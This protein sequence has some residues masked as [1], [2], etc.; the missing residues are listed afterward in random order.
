MAAESATASTGP[1]PGPGPVIGTTPVI[2][3]RRER[4]VLTVALQAARHVVLE[5]P[6]GTGKSTLLRS[7]ARDLDQAVVFVEGNAELTPA[8]LVG[9]YDPAQ[10][11]AEGYLPS[12]FA[13]GPL[14]QAMRSGALLYLEEFNRVP[15]ETL[16]VLITV[17]AEGEIAVPRLGPVRADEG[18]RLIAAMNPFDAIGTA[19]VSQ[20]IAD[21][22]CRV[23]LDYQD[24]AAERS[25]VRAVTG[26]PDGDA[27]PFAVAFA[28][29]TR[30][31]RDV[32]MGASVRG[33][34]DLVLLIDGL[35]RLR[36]EAAMT[37]LT[38]KDAAYAALSGRI[39]MADGCDRSPESV[40]DEILGDLWPADAARPAPADDDTP[41]TSGD[42]QGKADGPPS[43]AGQGR[44]PGSR[45]SLRRERT[46][47]AARRSVSRAEL[48]SRHAG[49]TD[50]SP[51]SGSLD[52]DALAALLAADP[53]AAAALLA[54]LSQATDP[55]LRAAA[56]Q[57]A[58]RI[59]IQ[60]GVAGRRSARGPRRIRSVLRGEGDVDLDRTLDRLGGT[61]PPPAED[62][63]TR[64]WQAHR[65]SVCLLVDS[66]G[67][68][69]GL[70]VAMA[71]VA[72][73]SVLLAAHGRLDTGALAFSG[74][75]TVLQPP[76]TR[77]PPE[78]IVSR[79]LGLRGHGMTDIAAALRSAA[80]LLSAGTSA[81]AERRVILMS[82][83]LSTT[84]G[85]PAAAL[86]G[87]ERLDVLCPAPA[88]TEPDPASIAAAER[89]ARLG[90]GISQPVRTLAE[91]PAALTRLLSD[92]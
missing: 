34:I 32:R 50:V 29:A 4:E 52:A 90:G 47:G 10:V 55:A 58:A 54:D 79:L 43:G 92:R 70:S 9:Q 31:H 88:G 38:A 69:S 39:R 68:M 22:I 33:A 60:L 42:G 2:G 81:A 62:L 35:I 18:F 53:D 87:I 66:S 45:S 36:A 61:W 13:D 67:S 15:E 25:I 40:L 63:V 51:E 91:I 56:R 78:Q 65:R 74:A 71:A 48:A 89:L 3:L 14:L 12:S 23:V 57:L 20:A 37:R 72:T 1:F 85:D 6:P 16:N 24:A 76:G 5:G 73:A 30:V 27:V 7:I 84:G 17:L 44:P 86:A 28:R 21:R 49:F 41:G 46:Q 64:S 59:F 11:L 83:C 77:Q 82:D 8:R 19:R 80:E 26:R 75:V